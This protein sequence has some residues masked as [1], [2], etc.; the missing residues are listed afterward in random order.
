M[1]VLAAAVCVA[2][3]RFWRG[4]EERTNWPEL[5]EAN[6]TPMGQRADREGREDKGLAS[7]FR[8]SATVVLLSFLSFFFLPCCPPRRSTERERKQASRVDRVL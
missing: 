5:G 8:C 3:D 7:R 1:H 4:K 2:L 6:E